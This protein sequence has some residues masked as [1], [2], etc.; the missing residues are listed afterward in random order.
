MDQGFH[1][2]P[3][4]G[5]TLNLGVSLH[6]DTV[7]PGVLP[8]FDRIPFVL[9]AKISDDVRACGIGSADLGFAVQKAI[10]LI[11]ICGFSYIGGND[12]IILAGLG[13]TVHL[14][15]EQH[16]NTFSFEFSR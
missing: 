13:D 11:E 16:R 4:L 6:E 15:G 5:I 2:S 9:E 7:V 8:A 12:L 14:N 1:L 3:N 10:Q